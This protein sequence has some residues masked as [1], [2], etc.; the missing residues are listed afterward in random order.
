[1]QPK[2][3]ASELVDR[4]DAFAKSK[5]K[6]EFTRTAIIREIDSLQNVDPA[7]ASACRGIM[8][9]IARDEPEI[10]KHFQNAQRLHPH[11][12]W[13]AFHYS[14]AL[15]YLG[16]LRES[17]KMVHA[18]YESDRSD[19]FVLDE[20]IRQSIDSGRA[21]E[22]SELMARRDLLKSDNQH[23]DEHSIQSF[24]AFYRRHNVHDDDVEELL[25]ATLNV[26]SRAGYYHDIANYGVRCDG[27]SEWFSGRLEVA[28][29]VETIVDL[30]MQLAD[31]QASSDFPP[32][33][34]TLVN[35]MFVPASH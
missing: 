11:D 23:T 1:M 25:E 20:L 5:E 17:R 12:W 13:I 4:I 6:D 34:M 21:L 9:T 27:E 35:I 30:N 15:H 24:S 16:Y 19:L 31:A 14:R 2:T 22:A 8:A 3:K 18:I 7:Y 10:R 29:P 32:D 28:A 33:L 26:L